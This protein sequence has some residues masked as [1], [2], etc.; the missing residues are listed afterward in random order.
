MGEAAIFIGCLVKSRKE[1]EE[2]LRK[3]RDRIVQQRKEGDLQG[4]K[5][6]KIVGKRGS[7]G[8]LRR[9]NIKRNRGLQLMRKA[10]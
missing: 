4:R 10:S 3:E 8:P 7:R 6:W 1:E 9:V 5:V 2:G